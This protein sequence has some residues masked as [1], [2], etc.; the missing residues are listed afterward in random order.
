MEYAIAYL[1]GVIRDFIFT[2]VPYAE[3]KLDLLK[4]PEVEE[5]FLL[6]LKAL[7]KDVAKHFHIEKPTHI[8]GNQIFGLI[9]WIPADPMQEGKTIPHRNTDLGPKLNSSSCLA[10]NH[11]SG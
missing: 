5:D 2:Q 10:T 9:V 7:G 11:G 6:L 3:Q 8:T 1:L 4:I